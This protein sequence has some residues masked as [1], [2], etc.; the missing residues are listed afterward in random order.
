MG[1]VYIFDPSSSDK[2]SQYRGGGRIV[3]ILKENFPEAIFVNDL[4][5]LPIR[6][7]R[8]VSVVKTLII[9]FWQ[10]FFPPLINKRIGTVFAQLAI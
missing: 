7:D 9:P 5:R 10:P 3:Q 1:K 8:T 2:L 6:H 4:D